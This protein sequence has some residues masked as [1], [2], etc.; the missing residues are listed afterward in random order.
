LKIFIGFC[1]FFP[2][3]P[4][5]EI[6]LC[7]IGKMYSCLTT[8]SCALGTRALRGKRIWVLAVFLNVAMDEVKSDKHTVRITGRR[9]V[10]NFRLTGDEYDQLV[11]GWKKTTL[12]KLSAYIRKVLFGRVLTVRT[13]NVS[14]DD[15]MA[16]LILLKKELNAIGVNINQAT[17]RLHTLDHLPQMQRWLVDWERDKGMLFGQIILI[18]DQLAKV[19]EQWLQ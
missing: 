16:E 12:K 14:L 8:I 6:A 10:I 5:G 4:V 15:F 9:R 18:K 13:R 3:Q 2:H 11:L 7:A 19:E 17:H 1:Y